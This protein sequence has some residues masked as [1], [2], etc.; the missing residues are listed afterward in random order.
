MPKLIL[1]PS[2][3]DRL[4]ALEKSVGDPTLIQKLDDETALLYMER[5]IDGRMTTVSHLWSK[6]I[7]Q[8]PVIAKMSGIMSRVEQAERKQ[9][10][11][12]DELQDEKN[13][14][15]NQERMIKKYRRSIDNY[16]TRISRQESKL[17]KYKAALGK[18]KTQLQKL[19]KKST[20]KKTNKAKKASS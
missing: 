3:C 2:S 9:R 15:N 17:S 1:S 7:A 4:S 11:L 14:R 6:A 18:C 5:V 10:R 8:Y 20:P 19:K 12:E 13:A 16:Y